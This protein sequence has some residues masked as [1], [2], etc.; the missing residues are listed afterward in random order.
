M[1]P[2]PGQEDKWSGECVG[3]VG[4]R[5]VYQDCGMSEKLVCKVPPGPSGNRS[6]QKNIHHQSGILM[7]PA[8]SRAKLAQSVTLG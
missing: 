7:K 3:N 1:A 5:E 4:V 8:F 6:N 2:T